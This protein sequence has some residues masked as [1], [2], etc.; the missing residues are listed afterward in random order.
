MY[1]EIHDQSCCMVVDATWSGCQA[2][3]AGGV[4]WHRLRYVAQ[5]VGNR[6]NCPQRDG[7]RLGVQTRG[8][9]VGMALPQA[10]RLAR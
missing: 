6:Q 2:D 10:A 8:S 7:M 3:D 4:N 5:L 9:M 1:D